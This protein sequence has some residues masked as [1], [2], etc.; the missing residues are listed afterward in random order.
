[1]ALSVNNIRRLIQ[2]RNMVLLATF[3]GLLYV[4]FSDGFKEIYPFIN[5]G[6]AG[7]IAGLVIATLELGF[8][9][10]GLRKRRFVYILILR[11]S[12]YFFF[13]TLL[14]LNVLIV[15]RMIRLDQSYVKVLSDPAFQHY[16]FKED[17]PIVVVYAIVFAFS[18]NFTRMMSRK[19]GQ[20]MLLSYVTGTYRKPVTQERIV[21]FMKLQNSQEISEQLGSLN[22]YRF[23]N[24]FF[25]DITDSIIMHRGIIYEYVED[26]IVVTWD[27]NKGL[28]NS[29]C[30]RTF[31]HA[32]EELELKKEA[33]FTKYK[34]IPKPYA[35]FHCG[36]LIRAE[37]GDVKSEIAFQGDVMNTTSRILKEC[38]DLNATLLASAHLVLRLDLP[39]IYA[40]NSKGK[41]KLRGKEEEVELYEIGEITP[42]NAP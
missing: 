25:Y 4:V 42:I 21:M 39:V 40:A 24:D 31:F 26:L 18:V 23:L 14:I 6:I 33:Y 9:S 11:T 1:M 15:S 30:I 37:I 35:A 12:L 32:L 29:N 10:G 19:L 36:K 2:G 41:I 17:F 28:T 5:G 7:F 22:F 34:V 13:L 38:E 8:F 3:L 20:G 27:I 16:I